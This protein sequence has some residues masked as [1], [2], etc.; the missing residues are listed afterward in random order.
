MSEKT[1]HSKLSLSSED[2]GLW[3]FVRPRLHEWL[4]QVFFVNSFVEGPFA[5]SP[6]H[7]N[8]FLP[9][10]RFLPLVPTYGLKS[11]ALGLLPLKLMNQ[12]TQPFA[13]N[14]HKYL[15]SN[16]DKAKPNDY[17]ACINHW[18]AI[19]LYHHNSHSLPLQWFG[20]KKLLC[21]IILIKSLMIVVTINIRETS[22]GFTTV[23]KRLHL[24]STESLIDV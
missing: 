17:L 19:K 11:N 5:P 22:A 18:L 6:C 20:C 14:L 8:H 15:V 24:C 10:A 3:A 23:E 16:K 1:I 4:Q 12:I 2:S 9:F 13:Q 21:V 7:C